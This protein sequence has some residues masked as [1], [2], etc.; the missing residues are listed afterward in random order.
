MTL[1]PWQQTILKAMRTPKPPWINHIRSNL[2]AVYVTELPAPG[3][4]NISYIRIHDNRCFCWTIN[5]WVEQNRNWVFAEYEVAFL[6][7]A[8]SLL[9]TNE[10]PCGP[11]GP[12]PWLMGTVETQPIIWK[13]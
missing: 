7:Q 3:R 11:I 12:G 6:I 13:R 1:Q 4:S 10:G 5:G 9:E 2:R 8:K